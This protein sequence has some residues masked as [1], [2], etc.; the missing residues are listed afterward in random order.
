M[1]AIISKVAAKDMNIVQSSIVLYSFAVE[2]FG[3]DHNLFTEQTES[4]YGQFNPE[5]A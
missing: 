4:F 5:L 2:I 1:T 3:A